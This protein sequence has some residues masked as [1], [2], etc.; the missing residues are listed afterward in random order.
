MGTLVTAVF[1]LILLFGCLRSPGQ[2]TILAGFLIFAAGL[3]P[4]ALITDIHPYFLLAVLQALTA[5]P[6]VPIGIALMALGRLVVHA[7][8]REAA[9]QRDRP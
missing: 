4:L 9:R 3:V 7:E 1:L 2:A 8:R 5:T 6:A